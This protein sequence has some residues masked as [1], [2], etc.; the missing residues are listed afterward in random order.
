MLS[1]CCCTQAFSSHG[2]GG[3]RYSLVEVL[4]LLIATASL[5]AESELSV[6]QL[7][8]LWLMGSRPLVQ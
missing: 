5:V 1:L 2:G 4:G 3:G 7:Q 8:Q 6:C